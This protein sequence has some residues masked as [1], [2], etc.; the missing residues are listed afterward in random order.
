MIISI[1]YLGHSGFLVNIDDYYIMIDPFIEGNPN[2]YDIADNLNITD[3]LL[4]HGHGDHLG[5]SIKISKKHDAPISAIFELANYCSKKRALAKGVNLGGKIPYAWGSVN[6]LPAAHSSSTPD[7][8]YA[9]VAA[10]LLLNINDKKIYHA[11]DTGLHYD[12]KMV[13]EF[14][15]PDIALLPV[16]GHYTMG[17]EEAVQAT[18]WLGVKAVIPMHYNTFEQINVDIDVFKRKLEAETHAKCIVLNP[19]DMHTLRP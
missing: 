10:S 3:I 8:A 5:D 14:Y 6:W 15:K 7:G 16:G 12:L 9:G 1:R 4:T 11:G 13:G 17:F 19:G 2:A 18:K